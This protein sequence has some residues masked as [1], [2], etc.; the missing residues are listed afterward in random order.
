MARITWI[1]TQP[2]GNVN[3]TWSGLAWD[4]ITGS[5][6]L[7]HPSSSD[8]LY[9]TTNGGANW[10]E[11]QPAGNAS[12]AW[13]QVS[14]SRDG[15][16][17]LIGQTT[18]TNSVYKSID[19]GANWSAAGHT[20]GGYRWNGTAVGHNGAFLF[21]NSHPFSGTST[22]TKSYYSLNSGGSW[23]QGASK[24]WGNFVN[25]N[26]DGALLVASSNDAFGNNIYLWT[27]VDYGVNWTSRTPV[28]STGS[29]EFASVS[30]DGTKVLVGCSN[31]RLHLSTDS[32]VNYTELRPNGNDANYNWWTGAISDDGQRIAVGNNIAIYLS[33]DGGVTWSTEGGACGQLTM[34]RDGLIFLAAYG[35]RLYKGTLKP[36][37]SSVI[38]FMGM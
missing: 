8:R 4:R 14:M 38:Y 29:W 18:D 3:K 10:A 35:N 32:G 28:G 37:V 25:C 7:A 30:A 33:F 15:Q 9:L 19:A 24:I 36:L 5:T 26:S 22:S 20:G 11:T 16:V 12:K 17:F 13:Q 34:D 27:S 2:A 23:T 21:D 31:G 6:I 1:E